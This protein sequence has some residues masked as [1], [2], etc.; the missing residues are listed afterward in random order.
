MRVL[1][2]VHHSNAAAG[3]FADS[4]A[5]A[6]CELV[7]WLPHEAAPPSLD[8]F[9]AAII[10]GGEAQVDDEHNHPWLRPEKQ[11]LSGLLERRIPTLGVCLGSQLLAEAAGGGARRA[12]APEIGWYEIELTAEAGSDPLLGELPER[13]EGFQYH[14]YEWFL[15][16]DATVLARSAGC[17]QAFRLD[18]RPAWG[19]QF[20]PEVTLPDLC[21]WLD[22]WESDPGAAASGL[23]PTAIRTESP[24]KI[25]AWNE[26]GRGLSARFFEHV[27]A[28]AAA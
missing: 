4:A 14:H 23:D 3:V 16:P 9:H 21:S 10:L 22:D 6:G 27:A 24:G 20:H 19:V 25:G 5:E 15:P 2:S 7:E 17:L 28:G 12:A 11:L 8:G 1:T 18:H 13:F 26:L